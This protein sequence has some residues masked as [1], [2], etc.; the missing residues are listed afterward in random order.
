MPDEW[1]Q[2]SDLYHAALKL[3]ESERA[4]FLQAC[5]ASD[6]VRREVA[7]LLANERSGDHLLESPA[8]EVA[9]RMMTDN[10]PVL[11]TGQTLA[12][13]QIKG[14]LG[15][16]GMGEVYRA[17]DGKLGRDVA[18]KTLPPEFARDPDRVARFQRE[19]KL[20]ASL[21][22]PNIAAIYGLEESGGTNFLVLELVEGETLAD[23]IKKNA[24][25]PAALP[26]ILRLALQIAEALE[27]A[28]EKGVIHRDLKPAN[29]KVTPEGKVKVLDFGLAKAFT[30]EAGEVNL[31]NSPTISNAATQQGVILGTAAYMSPEQAR[32]KAVDKRTD[33][34]A[35]G[36]VLYEMLTG[37][38]AFQ[39]EDVTEVLAA[40]VK[41]AA[42]LDLLPANLHPRVREVIARCLQKDLKRRYQG[43]ADASYD[44]EQALSDPGGVLMQPVTTAQPRN[45]LKILLPW[46]VASLILGAIITG[47]AVWKFKPAEPQEAIR[48]Y[49]DLPEGQ[50]FG[51]S[52]TLA[53]S[54]DGKQ[55][56]YSTLKGLYIRSVNQLVAKL[57]AGTEGS[58]RRPFFSPDGTAIGYF[59]VTDG[60]LK[61]IPVNGGVSQ[62]LCD[63]MDV[64]GAWW[65]KDNTIAYSQYGRDIMRV[66]ADG[67]TPESIVKLK[68]WILSDP[69]I[70]PDGESILYTSISKDQ[71]SKIMVQ[72]LKSGEP[73]ELF[74]GSDARYIPTKQIIYKLP[75]NGDL[76]AIAF[77][78]DRLKVTGDPIRME[79]GVGQFAV[80][81]A[82]ALAY[83]PG[84]AGSIVPRQ[85]LVWVDREGNE[86]PLSADPDRYSWFSISPDGKQVALEVM[87][88]PKNSIWIWDIDHEN[89]ARLTHDDSTYDSVPIWTPDGKRIV[90]SSS[91]ENP[92]IPNAICDICWRAADGTG[93][94]EKLASS[95]GRALLS[96]S[97][98]IDGKKLVLT[99]IA[100]IAPVN[101]D[102]VTLSMEGEHIIEPLLQEKDIQQH[103]RISSLDGRWMAYT[104]NE[105]GKSEVYVRPVA[106]VNKRK[107]LVSKGG[108]YGPPLWSPDG[109]ELFYYTGDAVM[110]VPVET[111]P[112]FK[113]G[114]PK[115]LFPGSYYRPWTGANVI[116]WD[117]DPNGKRFLILKEAKQAAAEAPRKINVVLNWTE[118][119]KQKA[120]KK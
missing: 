83:I 104:S 11:T 96:G 5:V 62:A 86:T 60:K 80:S 111:K 74:A 113:C 93:E 88:T 76:F 70:L 22:H 89:R 117:I 28:H 52:I 119:L 55:I 105:T 100:R 54:P 45:K 9:A 66:S 24:A 4:A 17:H 25:E 33:I 63:A 110:A 67:G 57:I 40:V 85:I 30:G 12:H 2:I 99:R 79:E 61:K 36:C 27:A 116:Y 103:P 95:P 112:D 13:Y 91:R 21:N 59:S 15:K 37:Q 19:A 106:D 38:A 23:Y 120:A 41:G 35:F 78:P 107:W 69:Q 114:K 14:L 87:S 49:H 97:W 98:S 43:I 81:G 84:I 90:Y 64:R 115:V 101:Y 56:V 51:D 6:G 118:E 92:F 50:E 39:G 48:F 29:I 31:S 82:G 26:G 16:G 20:L 3:P 8:L 47:A 46:I 68:S 108:G 1:K 44:I 72:S 102:I 10:A 34:W 7:S 42:N 65:N 73:K 94:A 18:I 75:N 58:T 53:V 109:R 32:G 71:Q 77:D